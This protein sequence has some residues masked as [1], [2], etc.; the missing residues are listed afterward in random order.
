MGKKGLNLMIVDDDNDDIDFLKSAVVK[1][2]PDTQFTVCH[3]GA[4]AIEFL[5]K[6]KPAAYPSTI[7]NAIFLDLNMPIKSGYVTYEEI[8]ADKSLSGIPVIILTSSHTEQDRLRF[9][10]QD[11]VMFFTKPSTLDGYDDV[12]FATLLF[13]HAEA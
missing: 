10:D 4:E 7:P 12:A 8:R 1:Q 13:L 5:K 6:N 11:F 3:N 9:K 2:R